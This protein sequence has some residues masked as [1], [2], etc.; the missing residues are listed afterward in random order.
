M[1]NITSKTAACMNGK[2]E[3]KVTVVT[4][5]SAGFGLRAARRFAAE[6]AQVFITGRRQS[7]LNK[8][9]TTL[10]GNVTAI[11]GGRLQPRRH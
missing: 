7:E 3:I 2:L 6:G 10:E 8:A 1:L 9:V 5:G 4:G 11:Q